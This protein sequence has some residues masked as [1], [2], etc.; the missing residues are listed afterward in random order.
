MNHS[1]P[2]PQGEVNLDSGLSVPVRVVDDA[3]DLISLRIQHYEAV[4]IVSRT[5]VRSGCPVADH[6]YLQRTDGSL[7][8]WGDDEG[9]TLQFWLDIVSQLQMQS[10]TATPT[11]TSVAGLPGN[12]GIN[13]EDTILPAWGNAPLSSLDEFFYLFTFSDSLPTWDAD[14]QG[15]HEGLSYPS[16]QQMLGAEPSEGSLGVC[17]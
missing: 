14:P 10:G 8:I 15:Y 3:R 11:T 12:D 13:P 16:W 5:F 17:V 2:Y 7:V 9:T 6:Q 1:R 4:F